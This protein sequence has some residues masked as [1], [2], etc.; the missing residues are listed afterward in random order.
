MNL[1]I[2]YGE[3]TPKEFFKNAYAEEINEPEQIRNNT[4]PLRVILYAKYEKSDLTLFK[5]DFSYL[6]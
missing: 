6:A 4:K 1:K 5:S 3:I 2:K